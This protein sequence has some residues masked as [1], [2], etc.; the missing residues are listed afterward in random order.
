MI[1]FAQYFGKW[2]G[3]PDA[4]PDRQQNAQ[5]LL[6]KVNVL[7][8]AAKDEGVP[9][10]INPHTG[11]QVS[12]ETLG[13]FR[14]QSCAIGAPNSKH[15]TGHA[16]DVYDPTNAIDNWLDDEKLEQFGLYREH[17]DSTR[18]WCHLSDVSPSS[19][20]RTFQP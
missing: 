7:L 3:H 12:G 11:S 17:P 13:G 18:S 9:L 5:G 4:T 8:V 14:P 10:P 16:V 19:G 20:R 1:S 6:A 15:K 2:G